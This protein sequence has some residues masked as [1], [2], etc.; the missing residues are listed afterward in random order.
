LGIGSWPRFFSAL[1]LLAGFAAMLIVNLPGH[2]EFDSIRQLIEGQQGHY[3]NWHPPVMSWLLGVADRIEHGAAPFVIF[4]AVMSYAAIASLLFAVSKPSWLS[5]PAALVCVLLPQLFLFQAIVWKDVLF[6]DACLVGFVL[7]AHAAVQWNRPGLRIG[8]IAGSSLF[9][10]LAILTR[11]SGVVI[12]PCVAITLGAISSM[13]TNRRQ[14]LIYG[15][16]FFCLSAALALAANAALQLRATQALGAV[17]QMEDLQLY[18]IGGMLAR[19]PTL[20]LAVLE[21]ESPK[22][23]NALKTR[24]ARLY[25]P[26]GHDRLT[27]D[28]E[29]RS[30]IIASV[31]LVSRQWRALVVGNPSIYLAVRSQNFGWLFLSQHSAQCLTYAVGVIGPVADLKAAGL[32]WRYD[33]RD[34]WL[35]EAYASPLLGTPIFSHPT[36]AIVGLVS[37]V[38]LLRRRRPAD[39]AMAGLLVAMMFYAL[40]FFVISIS[41]QYRYLY[42]IDLS[43]IAAGFYLVA[44]LSKSRIF[45]HDHRGWRKN[46]G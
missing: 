38:I 30:F 45:A 32:T 8:L 12:L 39:I 17:E 40:S 7:L 46:H 44:T 23:A 33:S 27:D 28:P 2:L 42:A 5:V 15:I 3:S 36:F 19:Q 6:A 1:T 11:Q 26:I 22:L 35:E 14:G 41:C 21:H 29:I 37:L 31:S 43:S 20:D 4:D 10:M 16:G 25:T 13:K 18:D 34:R 24:G 9:T